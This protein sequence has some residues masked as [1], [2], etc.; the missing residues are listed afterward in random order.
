MTFSLQQTC[1][2]KLKTEPKLTS[3]RKEGLT[4]F[5]YNSA[6]GGVLIAVKDHIKHEEVY[7]NILPTSIQNAMRVIQIKNPETLFIGILHNPDSKS[8]YRIPVNNLRKLFAFFEKT[9]SQI[10]Y[11]LA[12]LTGQIQTGTPTNLQTFTSNKYFPSTKTAR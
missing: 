9:V 4:E 1:F 8:P 12:T 10:S 5:I 2:P 11:L 7:I 6:H 3:T